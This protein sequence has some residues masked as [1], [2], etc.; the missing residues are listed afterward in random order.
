MSGVPVVAVLGCHQCTAGCV[1]WASKVESSG[2]KDP[3]CSLP[4]C[5]RSL[6]LSHSS[7]LGNINNHEFP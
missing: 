4:H 2:L 1:T 6:E 3:A 5:F 7:C